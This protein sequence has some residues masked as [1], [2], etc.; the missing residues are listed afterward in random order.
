M[1]TVLHSDLGTVLHS[2][3]SGFG[4]VNSP[5]GHNLEP[6]P[7]S[8]IELRRLQRAIDVFL[9]KRRPEPAI[10]PKLDMGVRISGG[11]VEIFE[12][13]P[14]WTEPS[15]KHESPVAKATYVVN[16]K[17]WKIF[18]MRSDLKWHGYT[19]LPEVATL[20]EFLRAVDRDEFA[21]FFG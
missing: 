8:E 9:A 14:R 6:M 15:V 17:R 4:S 7:F 18:W 16:R 5:V 19:P 10:R 13:R 12:I 3:I 21:C 11:S 1:G 20:E 2:C